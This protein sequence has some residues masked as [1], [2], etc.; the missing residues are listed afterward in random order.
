MFQPIE[1]VDENIV[2]YYTGVEFIVHAW[3]TH[4]YDRTVYYS[5]V[6]LLWCNVHADK[7]F[8]FKRR[9]LV[10]RIEP[11]NERAIRRRE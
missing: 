4:V 2:T 1:A 11:T 6:I 10:F 9:A 3:R 8:F 7:G 5:D